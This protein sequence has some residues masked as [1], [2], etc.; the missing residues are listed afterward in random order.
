MKNKP[1]KFVYIEWFDSSLLP[2]G[3][4]FIDDINMDTVIIRSVGSVLSHDK[5]SI[6]IAANVGM[7]MDGEDKQASC[8]THIPKCCIQKIKK[9]K[10]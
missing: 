8:V 6:T 3:W 4:K 2:S 7:T 1:V 9:I 10:I 5:H